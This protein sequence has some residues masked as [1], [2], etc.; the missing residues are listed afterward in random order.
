MNGLDLER[1]K[2]VRFNT[3]HLAPLWEPEPLPTQPIHYMLTP[4]GTGSTVPA[5]LKPKFDSA[6]LKEDNGGRGKGRGRRRERMQEIQSAVMFLPLNIRQ[7]PRH[8]KSKYDANKGCQT[9]CCNVGRHHLAGSSF[10]PLQKKPQPQTGINSTAVSILVSNFFMLHIYSSIKYSV[11]LLLPSPTQEGGMSPFPCARDRLLMLTFPPWMNLTQTIILLCSSRRLYTTPKTG[12]RLGS[13]LWS[14][15]AVSHMGPLE[16]SKPLRWWLLWLCRKINLKIGRSNMVSHP[17][18]FSSFVQFVS[19][20][21]FNW[22][23]WKPGNPETGACLSFTVKSDK[24]LFLQPAHY[25]HP[26]ATLYSC[27]AWQAQDA[28]LTHLS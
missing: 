25:F 2:I 17:I 14:T 7:S 22:A 24:G 26:I 5:A 10:H 28:L 23:G 4:E 11:L 20:W 18:P 6:L 9:H 21:F 1:Q 15:R 12:L 3:N 13:F 27:S 16:P 19:S 8:W